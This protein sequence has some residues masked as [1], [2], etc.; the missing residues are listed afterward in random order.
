MHKHR[1][2][3]SRT[4]N[5]NKQTKQQRKNGGESNKGEEE[6]KDNNDS[7][8]GFDTTAIINQI[9]Y[10]GHLV[11][12]CIHNNN[13]S[14]DYHDYHDDDDDDEDI[15]IFRICR[16]VPSFSRNKKEDTQ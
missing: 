1:T 15:F 13:T 6:D 2:E 11:F 5:T 14:H 7:E 12:G 10:D 4:G 8:K 9:P 3:N 16:I